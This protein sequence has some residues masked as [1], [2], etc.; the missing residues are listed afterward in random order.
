MSNRLVVDTSVAFKWFVAYG[1][2][3]LSSSWELLRAHGD[4]KVALIAPSLIRIELAN[5]LV[6]SGIQADDA[7]ALLASFERTHVAI[8]DVTRERTQCALRCAHENRI[9]VYD[10][11]FLALAMELECPLVTADRRAFGSIPPDVA[12]IRLIL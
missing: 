5:Q 9:T 4:N 12:E 10:A 11:T 6:S 8:I 2:S 7:L 3:G 1:E